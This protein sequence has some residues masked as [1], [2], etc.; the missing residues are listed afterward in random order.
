MEKKQNWNTIPEIQLD[1]MKRK[2]FTGE[3]V[4]LVHNTV[5]S[6]TDVPTHN[7][8]HEQI[9]FVLSGECV[10][11]MEGEIYTLAANDM[12][13]VPSNAKHK[14]TVTSKEPLV[15]I[16]IFSPIREDFLQ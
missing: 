7:H 12:L 15:A 4:M 3:Y 13:L 5:D 6:G 10:V 14:V 16:D 11:E 2:I 1:I 8:H 9:V